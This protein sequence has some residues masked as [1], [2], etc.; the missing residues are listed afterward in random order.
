MVISN[1]RELET[2][3]KLYKDKEG[4]EIE[5]DW[6]ITIDAP[7]CPNIDCHGRL[8]YSIYYHP[9]KCNK[10]GRIWLEATKWVEVE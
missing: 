8:M 9:M 3:M 6:H 4:K 7:H 5:P 2:K 1:I 10:C